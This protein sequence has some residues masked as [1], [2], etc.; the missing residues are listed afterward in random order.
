M[1]RYG[2][3]TTLLI[4]I[5]ISSYTVPS[6]AQLGAIAERP[7]YSLEVS[8]YPEEHRA[9]GTLLIKYVN[10]LNEDLFNIAFAMDNDDKLETRISRARVNRRSAEVIYKF[11]ED[12]DSYT[13]FELVASRR[14]PPGV[15][16]EIE[17]NFETRSADKI[18]GLVRYDG[19]WFPRVLGP[20]ELE[21]SSATRDIADVDAVVSY[22]LEWRGALS[23]LI[24]NEV[25]HGATV[26]MMNVA[27]QVTNY[28]VSLGQNLRLIEVEFYGIK[29][30]VFTPEN[31]M[32]WAQDVMP[33]VH[34]VVEYYKRHTPFAPP[35]TINVMPGAP[36]KEGAFPIY[37]NTIMVHRG[38]QPGTA[39][40]RNEVAEAI[41]DLYWGFEGPDRD[42]GEKNSFERTLSAYGVLLYDRQ[43]N[44]NFD[45]SN[46]LR[47]Q[48]LASLVAENHPD[49]KQLVENNIINLDGSEFSRLFQG[50]IILENHIGKEKMKQ[51]YDETFDRWRLKEITIPKFLDV[52]LELT[53]MET[54][55]LY[56]SWVD[57]DV[58]IDDHIVSSENK[59]RIGG[60]YITDV[61]LERN[62]VCRIPLTI[63]VEME[64]GQ[65]E[66]FDLGRD[67]STTTLRTV[68]SPGRI[69]LDPE[70]KFPLLVHG[71]Q[72]PEV[73][74]FI[75]RTLAE[76]GLWVNLHDFLHHSNGCGVVTAELC[77]WYALA[78]MKTG[79]YIGAKKV[80]M[81]T[82]LDTSEDAIWTAKTQL[83][84]GKV[85]DLLGKRTLALEA[86]RNAGSHRDINAEAQLYL[87]RPFV[88]NGK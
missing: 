88:Q 59:G 72:D 86:Y 79:D 32:G 49:L 28:G 18:F 8:L 85:Y 14:M 1:R 50:F 42:I 35:L 65:I 62:P 24:L 60:R 76:K 71:K 22:P 16:S 25:G 3:V 19:D 57:N 41:V 61:T 82:K 33:D 75:S 43:L 17:I 73:V 80:L 63:G 4:L 6:L 64:N 12:G 31:E 38:D 87:E 70:K 83:L 39:K 23:G 7:L 81:D 51:V 34:Q 40:F 84:L 36:D 67:E 10:P 53:D 74:A 69:I 45:W 78:N 46:T 56:S 52:L 29:I 44:V 66:L 30:R 55:E 13:G 20:P 5:I 26:D 48:Y 47:T 15:V 54:A 37:A 77:Y 2:I 68:L 58:C 21:L 27:A 9:N 11:K